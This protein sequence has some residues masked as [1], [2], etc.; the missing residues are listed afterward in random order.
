MAKYCVILTC[1]RA[2]LKPAW[3]VAFKLRAL[4]RFDADVI[5]CS[6]QD[7]GDPKVANVLHRQIDVPEF[8]RHLPVNERLRDFTYWRI[9]AI[10]ILADLYERIV[11]LDT[12]LFVNSHDAGDLFMMDM[13]GH[14]LAA[15]LDVHQTVRANRQVVEFQASGLGHSAYFN[16]GVL[17]VDSVRWLKGHFFERMVELCHT[18]GQALVRHDQSLLNLAFK[19]NWLELSPIWN[20]QYSYRN[21][22]LTEWVSPRLIHFSGVHKP[23]HPATGAIPRRYREAYAEFLIALGEPDEDLLDGERP[24]ELIDQGKTLIK[25]LWY[26]R[27]MARNLSRFATPLTVIS[28]RAN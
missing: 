19:D 25:N 16:A 14:A 12:D 2:Y 6:A 28:H 17:M 8:I 1:D 9:P 24:V 18:H 22:F 4:K 5:V 20:W 3:F 27:A 21:S 13:H 10:H 26:F 23:W 7:L 11:Y 15:V